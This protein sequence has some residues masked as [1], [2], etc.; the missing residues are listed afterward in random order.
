[1]C[2]TPRAIQTAIRGRQATIS[3]MDKEYY[4]GGLATSGNTKEQ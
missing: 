3:P 4:G 1:M 2:G